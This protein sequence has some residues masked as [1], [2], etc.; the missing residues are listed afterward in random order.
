M[1][2]SEQE[3]ELFEWMDEHYVSVNDACKILGHKDVP[4]FR[5]ALKI[6]MHVGW[7]KGKR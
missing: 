1:I 7:A 3:S 2:S 5:D 4:S 6:A